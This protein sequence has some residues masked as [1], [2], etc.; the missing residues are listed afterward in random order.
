MFPKKQSTSPK[1][2]AATTLVS[3]QVTDGPCLR[4]GISSRSDPA[5][6]DAVM[7][8][9]DECYTMQADASAIHIVTNADCPLVECV[10]CYGSPSDGTDTM[11]VSD[12][13]D[14]QLSLAFSDSRDNML[15]LP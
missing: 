2:E 5:A 10:E 12:G 4:R 11:Q 7:G 3:H 1:E 8:D 15:P 9:S 6:K 14:Q 13:D